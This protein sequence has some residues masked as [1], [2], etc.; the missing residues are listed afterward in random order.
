MK[1]TRHAFT[2]A[3]VMV[4]LLFLSIGIFAYISLQIFILSHSNKFENSLKAQKAAQIWMNAAVYDLIYLGS[5]DKSTLP[6]I[7]AEQ[8]PDGLTGMDIIVSDAP[9]SLA[10]GPPGKSLQNVKVL[11]QWDEKTGP[12]AYT[13][14]SLVE[15]G[16]DL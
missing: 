4:A 1:S 14:T 2:L 7:P 12:R 16:N 3:E 9:D 11:V 5:F 10:P 6:G 15:K 13:L 8:L